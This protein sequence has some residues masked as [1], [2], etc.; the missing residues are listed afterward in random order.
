MSRPVIQGWIIREV[1]EPEFYPL[2]TFTSSG[3]YDNIPFFHNYT[4]AE[5]Q[6]NWLRKMHPGKKWCITGASLTVKEET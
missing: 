2:Y 6:L 5:D 4:A 1:G 3:G